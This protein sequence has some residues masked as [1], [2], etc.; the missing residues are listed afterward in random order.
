MTLTYSYHNV[1]NFVIVRMAD[2]DVIRKVVE[3]I[4]SNFVK[5]YEGKGEI[6]T[7]RR[8]RAKNKRVN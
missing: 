6:K 8:T 1:N 4:Y 7:I 2:S 5:I 3:D